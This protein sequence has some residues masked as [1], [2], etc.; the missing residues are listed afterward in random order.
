MDKDGDIYVA[1]WFNHRVQVFTPNFKYITSLIG[2]STFSK[3][4]WQ[5]VRS[6]PAYVQM[7]K[8]IS[9]MTPFMRFKY[10][11]AV[12]V[13]DKDS[14]FVAKAATDRIQIYQKEMIAEDAFS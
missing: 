10:P 8:L 6:N 7:Y 9:D 14:V 1:D 5:Q 13:D 2:Y 12:A 3:W 11:I 4:G